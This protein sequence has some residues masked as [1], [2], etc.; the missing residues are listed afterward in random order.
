MKYIIVNTKK[1]MSLE[2]IKVYYDNISKFGYENVKLIICPEKKHLNIFSKR[3]Y[4]LGAQDF[5]DISD[6]I[7]NNVTHCIVG[8]YDS[9]N[10]GD[11]D[12][13]ISKKIN[14]LQEN[15]I[16][17]ILCIGE[18]EKS[19]NVYKKL[20][21]QIDNIYMSIKKPE[22]IIVAYEP[23]WA[24]G[25]NIEIDNNLI[26]DVLIYI[27]KYIFNNYGVR[28][29]VIYGGSVNKDNISS[30][31]KLKEADGYLISSGALQ[32]ENLKEIVK[33]FQG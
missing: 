11:S 15:N 4:C 28:V 21:K 24:I 6:L 10:A 33:Y 13:I 30:L 7:D 26:E 16:K 2:K 17:P 14:I 31:N 32:S 19:E 8:H 27:K 23:F 18:Y 5:S 29:S 25:T 9:R 20:E 1:K 22:Y 3:N 12:Q